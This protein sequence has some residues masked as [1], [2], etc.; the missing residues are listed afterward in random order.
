MKTATI[1]HSTFDV[2]G[3]WTNEPRVIRAAHA[4]KRLLRQRLATLAT[5]R[6]V[7]IFALKAAC[8]TYDILWWSRCPVEGTEEHG[9]GYASTCTPKITSVLSS[10]CGERMPPRACQRAHSPNGF[11]HLGQISARFCNSTTGTTVS[12]IYKPIAHSVSSPCM[13]LRCYYSQSSR[14]KRMHA[15]RGCRSWFLRD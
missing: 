7:W 4:N 3:N 9:F 2:A 6:S 13:Q 14:D 12:V 1:T 8:G 10:L 5:K 15:R 11:L